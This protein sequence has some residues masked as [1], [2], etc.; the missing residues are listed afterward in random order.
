MAIARSSASRLWLL[1]SGLYA[2]K[3]AFVARL[4]RVEDA[5]HRRGMS[6]NTVSVV[7]V[8]VAAATAVALLAGQRHAL[9]WLAVPPLC[10]ARMACNAVDGS[11]ARRSG[12]TSSRGAVL[13]EIG[14]RVADAVTFGALAPA[15]G[16]ALALAVVVV[17]L[18][19]SFVAVVG[20]ATLGERVG[21]GP[22]GKPDRVAVLSLAATG[23]A[24]AGAGVLTAGAWVLVV[25]GA[26]TAV[27][28]TL[29]LWQRT[30]EA[31]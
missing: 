19:T 21:I 4:R 11:L 3:P 26:A 22:L 20:Q 18:A 7:A 2:L 12:T 10:F 15:V 13:N 8:V 29:V 30:G 6:A 27:R 25:A 17:A 16:T 28:R 14:D 24:F 23:A 9:L 5:A 1:C 31:R